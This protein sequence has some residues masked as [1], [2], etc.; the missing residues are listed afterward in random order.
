VEKSGRS[1]R[2]VDSSKSKGGRIAQL[3]QDVGEM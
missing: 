1:L 2:K 3:M